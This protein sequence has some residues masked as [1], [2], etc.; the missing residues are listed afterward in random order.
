MNRR[1]F[2]KELDQVAILRDRPKLDY[3][4]LDP[5]QHEA[6]YTGLTNRV[7]IIQGPVGTGKT[8]VALTILKAILLNQ[9]H[10]ANTLSEPPPPIV[11]ISH[12]SCAL[13]G[14]LRRLKSY[15]SSIL[16]LGVSNES[17]F[18]LK[19]WK[20]LWYVCPSDKNQFNSHA[21]ILLILYF[22]TYQSKK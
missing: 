6:V 7:A 2:D 18:S 4:G 9:Q 15:T 10:W 14:F 5:S 8:F 1:S 11:F 12:S 19:N 13:D 3:L 20:D 17:E 16:H 21:S 22:S